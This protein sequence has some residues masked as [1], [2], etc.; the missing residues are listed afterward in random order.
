MKLKQRLSTVAQKLRESKLGIKSIAL[1]K[2]ARQKINQTRLKHFKQNNKAIFNQL[3]NEFR[4]NSNAV[5][6][7]EREDYFR[8]VIS[9]QNKLES[10]VSSLQKFGVSIPENMKFYSNEDH[11]AFERDNQE[12]LKSVKHKILTER[13]ELYRVENNL[14]V[15]AVMLGI[16][17]RIAN[18]RKKA[19]NFQGK[20][21]RKT[22][23]RR[24]RIA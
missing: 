21:K 1:A 5:R 11:E 14:K 17:I 13:P 20:D 19:I 6:L 10:I 8:N 3:F 7:G 12:L 22:Y 15:V 2:V 16:N 9:V 4:F 23:D 24:E 18:R